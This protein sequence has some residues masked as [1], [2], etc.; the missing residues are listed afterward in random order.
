MPGLLRCVRNDKSRHCVRND[1]SRHCEERSDVAVRMVW[2]ATA[3]Q[4][5]Q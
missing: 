5:S 2:M 3:F 1:K 4:A